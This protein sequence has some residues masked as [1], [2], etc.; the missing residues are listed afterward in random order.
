LIIPGH[1]AICNT[2]IIYRCITMGQL[3][4]R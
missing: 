2:G 4:R 1:I 3:N